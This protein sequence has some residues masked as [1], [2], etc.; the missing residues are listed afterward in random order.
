MPD[1]LTNEHI[2]SLKN[3][4]LYDLKITEI[5]LTQVQLILYTVREF[6]SLRSRIIALS[7]LSL[8]INTKIIGNM[9]RS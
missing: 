4:S 1:N 2:R 6:V 9:S 8:R 3:K 7:T 5:A